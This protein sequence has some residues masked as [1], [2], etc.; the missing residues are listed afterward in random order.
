MN[1][2]KMRTSFFWNENLRITAEVP[3]LPCTI[4][5]MPL[6]TRE[7][8]QSSQTTFIHLW[9]MFLTLYHIYSSRHKVTY[10]TFLKVFVL[11]ISE[12][13][14]ASDKHVTSGG[15]DERKQSTLIERVIHHR[16][17]LPPPHSKADFWREKL[18]LT[19][20]HPRQS[21][22]VDILQGKLLCEQWNCGS[23]TFED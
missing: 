12:V 7:T 19:C 10:C 8:Q 3:H 5:Q 18:P 23:V 20:P 16:L 17:S 15:Q 14:D 6:K 4:N 1:T 11:V 9:C 13:A 2:V 22:F 21:G